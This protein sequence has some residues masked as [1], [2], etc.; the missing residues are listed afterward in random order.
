MNKIIHINIISKKGLLGLLFLMLLV[1]LPGQASHLLGG[2]MSYRYLG[3]ATRTTF[4]RY[5]VTVLVYVNAG[6][7]SLIGPQGR[8]YIEV[9]FY[10]KTALRP[11]LNA[12]TIPRQSVRS[13]TP[14][15]VGCPGI[16]PPPP[17]NLVRYVAE[18]LLPASSDGYYAL[19]TDN[20]RNIGITNIAQRS[21]NGAGGESGNMTLSMDMAPPL[22]PNASPI[23]TDTAV[24]VICQG[25][26]SSITNNAVDPDGDRLVYSFGTPYGGNF[27]PPETPL[28]NRFA[29]PVPAIVYAAG[30]SAAAPF[31]TGTG[32]TATL[33]AT[34]GLSQYAAHNAGTYV[35]AV[36]VDEYR[37]IN[38][39]EVL[40]GR[41]RRDIQLI[42]RR[43][44]DEG[45]TPALDQTT[46]RT[47]TVA[48]GQPL[49]FPI[50]ATALPAGTPVTVRVNSVLLDGSGGF[51]ATYNGLPGTRSAGQFTGVVSHSGV[52][53]AGAE[54][55]FTPRCGDAR[56]TPYDIVV[57]ATTPDC[58]GKSIS[59]VFQVLVTRPP[60][61][62]SLAGDRQVCVPGSA[63]RSY[64]AGGPTSASYRWRVQGGAVVGA[65]TG[66]GVQV[67]WGTTAGTGRLVV[68][69]YTALGCPTDSVIALV[70][71]TQAPQ[72]AVTTSATT[73]CA[74]ASTQLQAALAGAPA[75]QVYTWTGGE[76]TLEGAS[77]TVSPATTTTY[78]VTTASLG[79]DACPGI[80]QVT[81]V[82][83]PNPV[84]LVG[85]AL[86]LCAGSTGQLGGAPV[87][88]VQYQWSPAE[89]L[90]NAT[91]ANPTISLSN[92]TDAPR[93]LTYTLTATAG[94]GCQSTAAVAVTVNPAVVAAAG[95]D[96]SLCAN[97]TATLG[98]PARPGYTYRWSPATGLSDA[99]V[100][101]P[102]LTAGNTTA[103]PLLLT[104]QLTATSA[105]GC[106]ATA[107]VQVS[108]NAL[109]Q[110]VTAIQGPASVCP[111]V[112]GVTYSAQ[113][114]A[115]ADPALDLEWSVRGGLIRSGQGTRTITVDWLAARADAQVQVS[116][117]TAQSCLSSP[118]TLPVRIN[119]ELQTARPTGPLE[120]CQADGPFT[121]QTLFTAGSSYAW[122]IVG[123]TQVS[124]SGAS[125][126]VRWDQPGIGQLWVEETSNP[127]AGIRCLGQSASLS[128]TVLSS[129][130]AT[131]ALQ[132][133]AQACVNSGPLVFEL[134]QAAGSA[135]SGY[136]FELNGVALPVTGNRTT[137]ASADLLPGTYTLTARE[138]N[139]NGC[140][141]PRY[142]T[143]LTLHPRPS[144]LPISG[145]AAVCPEGLSGQRYTVAGTPGSTYV[146]TVMGGT[147][148]AG[149]GTN[150]LT[151]DFAADAG[152][153]IIEVV[154][155]SPFG[156]AGPHARLT[157][158]PDPGRVALRYVTVDPLD[159]GKVQVYLNATNLSRNSA[160]LRVL[161]R[162]AGTTDAF[163]ELATVPA[164]SLSYVDATALASQH[165]YDYQLQVANACGTLLRAP[166]AH[167]S[168]QLAVASVPGSGGRQQ[169]AVTLTWNAYQ[170]FAVQQYR[171]YRVADQQAPALL[172]T[173]LPNQ[174]LT[175]TTP[176]GDP[177][178]A[179]SFG[180]AQC[181][182][183]EAE[184]LPQ[185]GEGYVSRSNRACL[186]VASPLA[187]YNIITPN[188][189]GQNDVLTIDNV[190]LYPGNMLTIFTRWGEQVYTATNYQNTWGQDETL[191]AGVYYYLFRLAD[192][193]QHKGWVEIVK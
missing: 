96:R 128:V 17:V 60:G 159:N 169:G 83:T 92:A 100:A 77:I 190:R 113:L 162:A 139:R 21:D 119:L 186:E 27:G 129:P 102:V 43:C 93:L 70:D 42:T 114:A 124:S 30:Y 74:G 104:Y 189:D 3:P 187:F 18:V 141:G 156:C 150:S 55:T 98:A 178:G 99:T 191:A 94:P 88:G 76:Q 140:A 108:V 146:W 49:R 79:T 7:E 144:P 165:A 168:I 148:T 34:T 120:V 157:V 115:D 177:A 185:A 134:P 13:A 158:F 63:L 57:T 155:T 67:Q 75:G 33:S 81:V 91:S 180:R 72:I 41:T 11:L 106:T 182:Y 65:A 38:G 6:P 111:T 161:R 121:Y 50:E 164:A 105:P 127:S 149:Q 95:P 179:T 125:V 82:V 71:L 130:L 174:A 58:K 131:L 86:T 84:A 39:V 73:I 193:T 184:Q 175:Y 35:V 9:G 45:G 32:N 53:A 40:V 138:T 85:P 183:V 90:S 172:T 8:D 62:S 101:E 118:A 20:A 153:K 154:E 10:S 188:H 136:A 116:S 109:P 112:T 12:I 68:V 69:G 19:Y 54:F 1:A 80:G 142:T 14:A 137:L 126:V 66:S 59:D 29:L 107:Q 117:R 133:P 171:V 16:P 52:G 61:P 192:G 132:G 170:G 25:E 122:T 64:T 103:A 44:P 56:A 87:A 145:P 152:P 147:L 46:P 78:T 176:T 22:L 48:E 135:D 181:F 151:V 36:D 31:G 37:S 160:P 2:E 47:Y 173:V 51:V 28:P 5:E 166:V 89:G 15:V 23:F 167:S 143:T 163:T 24:A 110:P 26:V 97:Q 123:G 4:F